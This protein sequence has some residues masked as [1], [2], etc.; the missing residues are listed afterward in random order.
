MA[1]MEKGQL[2]RKLAEELKKVDA[3]KA[4][5]WAAFVKTGMHAER[6]P[7]QK[8]WWQTRAAAVLLS[9]DRLGPVGVQK[10]RVKY[11]GKKNRGHKPER[12]AKGS[13]NIL[14]KSLQQ[15]EKAG[16][17]KQTVKNGHKGRI[18][19]PQGHSFIDK[20]AKPVKNE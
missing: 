12:F 1:E 3:I 9:V 7:T 18:V 13:G 16:F 15:L 20:A 2:I 5:D 10:L 8:D 6:P 14:R 11:G 17:I 19:T 4:P